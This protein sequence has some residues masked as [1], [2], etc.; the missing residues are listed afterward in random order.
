MITEEEIKK[1]SSHKATIIICAIIIA[2]FA[3]LMMNTWIDY[4]V[5]VETFKN[6]K[7]YH[8]EEIKRLEKTIE[9]LKTL[10]NGEANATK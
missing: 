7:E 4:K 1:Q 5:K 9:L 2:F 3:F 6:I 8:E 10:K